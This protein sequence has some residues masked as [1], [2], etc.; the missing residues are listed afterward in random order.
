MMATRGVI[1]DGIPGTLLIVMDT[2]AGIVAGIT[3]LKHI[4]MEAATMAAIMAGMA[5]IMAGMAAIEAETDG[6][7][8]IIAMDGTAVGMVPEVYVPRVL[9]TAEEESNFKEVIDITGQLTV[10]ANV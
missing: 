2:A 3:V 10:L 9:T 8:D 7:V 6:D 4:T 1:L 5:A